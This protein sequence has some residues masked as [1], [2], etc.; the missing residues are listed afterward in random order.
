MLEALRTGTPWHEISPRLHV[1][2]KIIA[3]IRAGAQGREV[4]T[5]G[6]VAARVFALFEDGH[7]PIQAVIRLKLPP[8]LVNQLWADWSRMRGHVAYDPQTLEDTVE[9]LIDEHLSRQA[10]KPEIIILPQHAVVSP[11]A[12]TQSPPCYCRS[13]CCLRRTQSTS[14]LNASRSSTWSSSSQAEGRT[15]TIRWRSLA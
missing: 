7:K 14:T 4:P 3:R 15:R 5:E 8:A 9:E 6:Q 13:R 2:P 11:Q 10:V 12:R 1:S